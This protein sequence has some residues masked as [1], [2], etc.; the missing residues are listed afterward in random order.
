MLENIFVVVWITGIIFTILAI[1]SYQDD[2][3]NIF[4]WG[5]SFALFMILFANSTAFFIQTPFI[6]ATN[7]TNYTTGYQQTN[8]PGLGMICLGIAFIDVIGLIDWALAFRLRKNGPA[9]P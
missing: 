7:A 3:S 9:Q 4:Y 1:K 8:D 5:L 6:A 2:D